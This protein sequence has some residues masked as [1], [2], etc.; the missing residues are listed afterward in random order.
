MGINF[1][2]HRHQATPPILSIILTIVD[3]GNTLAQCLKALASQTNLRELEILVPFDHITAEARQFVLQY[4]DFKFID[5]G[6]VMKGRVPQNDLEKHAFYN[7]R[8]AKALKL[9]TGQL[10]AIIEDRGRPRPDWANA[11]T[12][13]HARGDYA[14]IGG[15]VENG[16]DRIWNWAVYF[17]DFGRYQAP[18]S[19]H[20]PE[21]LTDKYL[22]SA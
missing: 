6:C 16:I 14:A 7:V 17:C 8:R 22:L 12:A 11:M 20:D 10:V 5:L 4:P 19:D 1:T 15:A 18:L 3:G 2:R 21:Y 13:L 9:A